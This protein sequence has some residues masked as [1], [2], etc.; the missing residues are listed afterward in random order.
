MERRC[1]AGSLF[2]HASLSPVC[3]RMADMTTREPALTWR[4]GLVALFMVLLW[5]FGCCYLAV[6]ETLYSTQLLMVLGFAAILT[7][8]LLHFTTLFLIS[9][10]LLWGGT[11]ALMLMH[12]GPETRELVIHGILRSLLVAVPMIALGVWLKLRPL[13]R[14]ELVIVYAAVLIAIPWCICIK[15]VMESSVANLFELQ[16]RSE[17]Q[18]YSWARELPWWAP[19]VPPDGPPGTDPPADSATTEAVRG[20]LQGNG[21]NVPWGMWAKPMLYWAAMCLS[22]EA[23]L[24]GLLLLLRKR[25][26]E[27]E[28]LPFVWSQPAL[29]VLGGHLDDR[30]GRR[31]HWLLFAVGVGICLPAI[32][33]VGPSG[34]PLSNWTM[35]PWAGEEGIRGG[36]DLTELNL[37]PGVPLRLMWGPLVLAVLLLFPV[38]V[39]M[40]TALTFI[41]VN[42]LLPGIMRSMEMQVGPTIL[43]N[44]VKWGLRFGGCVGLVFWSIFF[45]LWD[46]L[47]ARGQGIASTSR[48]R[49]VLRSLPYLALLTVGLFG[50]IALG[51]YATTTVQMLILTGLVIVYA[52]AQVRQR[53]EGQLLTYDNN[54]ASHQL[55]GIQRDFLG[56]HYSLASRDPNLN[57]TGSSWATHW[58]QWGFAGQLKS[59]GPHNMLL[60]AFKV[61]HELKVHARD[62]GLAVA[63]AMLIVVLLTP[64]LYLQMIYSYGFENSYQGSLTSW[65]SFTQW[66]ERAA[67]YGI[68]STSKVF[69][70]PGTTFMSQY[71]NI[72]RTL[73]GVLIIGLLFV[74]RREYPR[75]PFSPVGVVL[76]AEVWTSITVP[77]SPY[78]IWFS[79]LIAWILKA[80]IFRWLGVRSYREKIQPGVIMLLCGMIFAMMMYLCRYA[81]LGLG[82][83]K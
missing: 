11:Y 53:A 19:T 57:V 52:V 9:Q 20:F 48:K 60:E 22:Y 79:F 40:T 21:G 61:G 73:A 2:G 46:W 54:I 24:M 68:H 3:V 51:S 72:F 32:L 1:I 15:S 16:Q 43:S 39:L 41:L 44:F 82:H 6:Y 35:V 66:S 37:I 81:A 12:T 77:F 74:L 47:R 55:T 23:M 7:V 14:G 50:F 27:H 64:P 8:F 34:E 63:L 78:Q 62:V 69:W 59:F 65:A 76:G 83:L 18:M 70:K 31:R 67:A 28:R 5:T 49:D 58:M 25:W 17:P 80:L 30:R 13:R 29:E 33:Y 36:V 10:V 56:D 42:L 38:D 4:S 71:A 75:F 45:A 26:I